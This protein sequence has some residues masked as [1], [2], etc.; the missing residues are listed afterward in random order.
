[1]NLSPSDI[2]DAIY[3]ELEKEYWPST[4]FPEQA[5]AETKRYFTTLAK[6]VINYITANGGINT[7]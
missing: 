2:A 1:M 5:V 7:D 6:G 3:S 4:P